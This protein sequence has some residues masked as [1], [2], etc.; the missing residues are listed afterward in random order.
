MQSVAHIILRCYLLLFYFVITS[1]LLGAIFW[2]GEY[3]KAEESLAQLF[4][5]VA[6]VGL[7][8]LVGIGWLANTTAG[9]MAFGGLGFLAAVRHTYYDVGLRLA[10]VPLIGSWFDR[11]AGKDDSER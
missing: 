4:W 6:L 3:V 8:Y 5:I 11:G 1:P 2:L 10:F 7:G 9:H